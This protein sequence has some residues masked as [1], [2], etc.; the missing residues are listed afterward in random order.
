MRMLGVIGGMSW[1]S[2]VEYYRLLNEG[3]QKALG[4]AHS[5]RI[6]MSSVEFAEMAAWM[7]RG[8]WS[9]VQNTLEVEARRLARCGAEAVIIASN[10]MHLYAS[11]VEAAAGVPVLHIA[12]AVGSRIAAGPVRTVGLM[13]TRYSMEKPFYR[14]R[15]EEKFGIECLIPE[16]DARGRINAIIF[17]EL[18][19]GKFVEES[20]S[21]VIGQAAEL[22]RRGAGAIILGCTELPLI[23]RQED[24]AVPRFDTMTAHAEEGVRFLLGASSSSR[25]PVD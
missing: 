12:D 17:D 15:L 1:V 7:A 14:G 23:V 25:Q 13:G 19:A 6:V 2:T 11:Q 21:Y 22:V 4:G 3:V 24:L 10:T 8:D 18:V 9:S 20:R 16:E 5:A